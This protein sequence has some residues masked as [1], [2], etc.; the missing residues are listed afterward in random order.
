MLVKP[1]KRIRLAIARK[2]ARKAGLPEP[3]ILTDQGDEEVF[4]QGTMTKGGIVIMA[5]GALVGIALNLM[6]VGEC[7]PEQ[8]LEG[9]KSASEIKGL[10][11][12]GVGAVVVGIGA[13]IGWKGRNRAGK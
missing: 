10:L 8:V 13:V 9:C 3:T 11:T 5:I 12:E 6:G 4:P 2:K 7:T 1:V